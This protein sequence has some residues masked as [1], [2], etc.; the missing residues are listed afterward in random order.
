MENRGDI[1]MMGLDRPVKTRL[2]FNTGV[3]FSMAWSP[4][5]K[6]LIYDSATST[7]VYGGVIKMLPANG[8]G[9]EQVVVQEPPPSPCPAFPRTE[10]SW[11]ISAKQVLLAPLF[12]PSRSPELGRHSLAVAPPQ[13]RNQIFKIIEFH[14]MDTGSP[15][16][17]MSRAKDRSMLHLSR[18]DPES[19]RFPQ[20][21]S[22]L[23]TWRGDSKELFFFSDADDTFYAAQLGNSKSEFTI[24][25]IKPLFK[26]SNVPQSAGL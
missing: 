14:R 2:T 9:T 11:F 3:H 22:G 15:T 4:D 18:P 13:V 26:V 16:S 19:G 10:N 20:E 8:N 25:G 6:T 1:W 7:S 23:P 5:G 17:R 21:D 12:T 24:T